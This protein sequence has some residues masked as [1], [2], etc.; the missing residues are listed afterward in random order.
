ME[1]HVR[2]TLLATALC[3]LF[4]ETEAAQPKI[5]LQGVCRLE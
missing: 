5:P 2:R 1:V 3:V 4:P